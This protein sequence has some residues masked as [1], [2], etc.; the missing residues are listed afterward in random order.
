MEKISN[1]LKLNKSILLIEASNIGGEGGAIT[2]LRE[3]LKQADFENQGVLQVLICTSRPVYDKVKNDRTVIQYL[4]HEWLNGGYLKRLLWQIF[5]LPVILKKYQP[6]LFIPGTGYPKRK[7]PFVTMFRNLLPVDTHEMDRYRYSFTWLR[8]KILRQTY[9]TSFRRA[10]GLICMNE[11]IF[12]EIPLPIK[13]AI[14]SHAIIPHGLSEIF[15]LKPKT[16]YKIQ[17][18]IRLLYVS[19]INLY[20]HQ[21]V[22][23]EAALK[24][25]NMGYDVELKLVGSQKGFGQERLETVCNNY[26][27]KGEVVKFIEEVS[28]D[29]LVQYYHD[30]DIFIFAST[31]ETFGMILLEAM[32]VG[33]PIISSDKSSMKTLLKDKGLYFD[34]EN[35]DSLIQ[36]LK[37]LIASEEL[38][39]KFGQQAHQEALKY[40]WKDTSSKTLAYIIKVLH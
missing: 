27:D 38:R 40:N 10:N 26:N 28:Q 25:K 14:R 18:K 29:N 4:N 20:K 9:F 36:N 39:E 23:A 6:L 7:Y 22:V 32:G 24:L 21:W 5:I 1:D 33:L 15:K 3:F 37:S 13:E 17:G 2:H 35:I 31:C 19:R 8:Y 16:E 34:V 11:Y 30:A 12:N